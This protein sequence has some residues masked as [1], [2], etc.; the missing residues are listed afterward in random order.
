MDSKM[1][2]SPTISKTWDQGTDP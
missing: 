1:Q 2:P